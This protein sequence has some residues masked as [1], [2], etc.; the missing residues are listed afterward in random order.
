MADG[1]VKCPGCSTPLQATGELDVD[2]TTY[3]V[4]QC[5]RCILPWTVD[6]VTLDAALTFALDTD[7]R[8][9][10]HESLEPIDVS[11]IRQGEAN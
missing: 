3:G 2:G 10:D 9:L 11:R 7:G 8:V 1:E 6:G 4:F 5:E